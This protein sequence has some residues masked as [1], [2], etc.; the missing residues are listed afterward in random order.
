[1]RETILAYVIFI[2]SAFFVSNCGM[3]PAEEVYYTDESINDNATYTAHIS[4]E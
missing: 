1:M 4:G 3:L 2:I